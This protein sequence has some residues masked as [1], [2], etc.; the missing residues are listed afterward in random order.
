MRAWYIAKKLGE[1]RHAAALKIQ[2]FYKGR[3]DKNSSFINAL[4]LSKIP[5]IYFLKE[6][7]PQFTKILRSQQPILKQEN[8]SHDDALSCIRDDKKYETIR[9]EEPDLFKY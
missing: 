8:L 3:F 7:R 2:K 6:Q 5:R 1:K 9:V 4:N